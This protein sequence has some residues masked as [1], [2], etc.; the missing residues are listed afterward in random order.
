MV[1]SNRGNITERLRAIRDTLIKTFTPQ[2]P[3]D[4]VTTERIQILLCF[5][6]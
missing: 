1:K 4:T 2:H 3:A 6:Y 5:G